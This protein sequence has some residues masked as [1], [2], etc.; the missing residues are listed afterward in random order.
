MRYRVAH[1]RAAAQS[2]LTQ[3]L[4][5]AQGLLVKVKDLFWIVV[6]GAAGIYAYEKI[7][8]APAVPVEPAAIVRP[9]AAAVEVEDRSWIKQREVQPNTIASN[10]SFKCDGRTSCPQMRSCAEATFFIQSCPNTA[11][12]GDRDGIPCEDQWCR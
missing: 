2:G 8:S 7:K 6:F 10:S 4:G 1:R 3:V 11:M 9:V 12:D 5:I